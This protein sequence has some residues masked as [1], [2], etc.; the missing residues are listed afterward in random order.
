MMTERIMG[1]F[2]CAKCGAKFSRLYNPRSRKP[3]VCDE[4]QHKKKIERDRRRRGDLKPSGPHY[5]VKK[6]RRCGKEFRQSAKVHLNHDTTF[7][8]YSYCENCR[9]RNALAARSCDSRWAAIGGH[10]GLDF[11]TA[12]TARMRKYRAKVISYK[13]TNQRTNKPTNQP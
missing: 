13:P 11:E 2:T 5:I 7:T 8:D 10:G 9:R 4:C 6:C 3:E 12:G 1:E